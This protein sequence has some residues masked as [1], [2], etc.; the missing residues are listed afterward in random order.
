M[1]VYH[2]EEFEK[3]ITDEGIEYLLLYMLDS[4]QLPLAEASGLDLEN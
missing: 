4:G 2:R 3:W 1:K